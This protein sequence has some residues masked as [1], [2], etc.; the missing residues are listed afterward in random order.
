MFNFNIDSKIKPG[1]L[2]G[3]YNIEANFLLSIKNAVEE[4]T[5][6]NINYIEITN[7]KMK[8]QIIKKRKEKDY[9]ELGMISLNWIE[10]MQIYLP[11][12]IIQMIDL[13][14]LTNAAPPIDT[15]KIYETLRKEISKIKGSYLTSNQFIIIKNLKKISGFEDS[16][17]SQILSKFKFLK[18]IQ[19]FYLND[20]NYINNFDIIKKIGSIVKDEIYDFYNSKMK[21]YRSKYK[22]NENTEQKEFAVKYLI[23]LFMISKLSNIINLDNSINYYDYILNAYNILS[24]KLI[25]KT[26]LFS[27][28]KI[29]VIYLEL[30]NIADFL[31]FQLLSLGQYSLNTIISMIIHH[32]NAFDFINF[33]HDDKTDIRVIEKIYKEMKHI[34]FINMVWKH[35]WF[36]FLLDNFKEINLVNI[37]NIALKGYIMDNLFHLYNFLMNEPNFIKEMNTQFSVEFGYTKKNE[38]YIEKIPKYYEINGERTIIGQLT[39]KENL[40]IYILKLIFRNHNML[41]T[42]TVLM[43]IE[44]LI[45]NSKTDYYDFFLFNKYCM[46]KN[47]STH[48]MD[49]LGKLQRKNDKFLMKFPMVYSNLATKLNTYILNQKIDKKEENNYNIYKMTEHLI[50]YASI[51]QN[52]L[53]IDEANKINELLSCD[54]NINNNP[55]VLNSFENNLFNIDVSYNAKEVKLLDIISININISLLREVIKMNITKIKV[56][57]PKSINGEKEKNYKDINI[58]QE[59]SKNNP[60]KINFNHLVKFFFK[61]LYVI[62]IQLFLDNHLIINLINKEKRNIVFH[63]KNVKE[64]L[65]ENDF[66]DVNIN[67]KNYHL[68]DDS[69][70]VLVGKKENH[71]FNIDYKT[72]LEKEDIFVKHSKA[73]IRIKSGYNTKEEEIKSFRFKTIN[74]QGYNNCENNK[75]I[76]EYINAKFEQNPPPFEFILQIDEQ[77]SFEMIYE[78]YFTLINKKCPDDYHII[79]MEKSINI[80]CIESFKYNNEVNASL[81]FINQKTYEKTYPINYPINII[82]YLENQLSENVIIKKLEY[83]TSIEA[84]EIYS[85]IEKLFSKKSNYKM[86][87]SSNEKI[88]FH[89]KIISKESVSGY[90][91]KVK[92]LW[93]S[94]NLF[95][96]TNFNESMLNEFIFDLT[97]ININQ[98]PLTIQGNYVSRVNKYQLKIKNLESTSKLIKF[99]M[100]EINNT[101]K[102]ENFI[103]CGKTDIN[104]ILLPLNELNLQYNIFDKMSGTHFIDT[105]ENFSY[106]FN[107]LITLN[108]YFIEDTKDKFE[109]KYLRNIIYYIPEIFKISN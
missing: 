26:Y 8:I 20:N 77:G 94:E 85:P 87:F 2:I 97:Y 102:E 63:D 13:T 96:H 18:E 88:S 58:N 10:K 27:E 39:D 65:N 16:I 21:N 1:F 31:M 54:L 17:K 98:M 25:K 49:I 59:L 12:V 14:E 57:F 9:G 66:M 91:G 76:L 15:N 105:N 74:K 51:S 44:H 64:I 6:N 42:E 38:K 82:S 62:H 90:I 34:H 37:N 69:K 46:K 4:E 3:F 53:S 41:T 48:F 56:Y 100:K 89:S 103:L 79:K 28:P 108:E 106:K 11:A 45:L 35:D 60:I 33:Y 50:V 32:L 19:I 70:A 95:N 71:L 22:T 86:R 24:N 81:Y 104:D 67:Q 101:P 109:T 99:S 83:E 61:N 78:I 40:G 92:I 23:K 73:V 80:Q 72:K 52:D 5:H 75:L 107:N 84:I 68:N 7:D 30:K 43:I 47:E 36:A 29:E 93:I 55:M